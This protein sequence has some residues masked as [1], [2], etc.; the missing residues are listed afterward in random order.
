MRTC[1]ILQTNSDEG[2]VQTVWAT[3]TLDRTRVTVRAA[4]PEKQSVIEENVMQETH[5]VGGKRFH[6]E[7]DPVGWFNTLHY[8]G[9]YLRAKMV[10]RSKKK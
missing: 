3:V 9:S 10:S 2:P 1:E 4:S 7:T 6:L 8:N 5:F